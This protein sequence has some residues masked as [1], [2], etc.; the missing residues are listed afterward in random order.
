M[1]LVFFRLFCNEMVITSALFI[2]CV[3]D[4]DARGSY[5]CCA[6]KICSENIVMKV[7]SY[8]T[9]VYDRK[10]LSQ[11]AAGKHDFVFSDKRLTLETAFLA[12]GCEAVT[13]FTSD[14]ASGEVLQSLSAIG[15][16]YVALRSA[17]YDHADLS[18]AG[19]L[20]IRI[21]NVPEYSPYSI[22]E[23]AVAM[24]MAANRKLIESQLLLQLHDFRLDTLVGFDVHGKTVGVVGTGKIGIAFAKIMIGF[25]AVVLATDPVRN[26]DVEKLGIKYVP[27]ENLVETSDIISIHCPLNT[28]TRDLFAAAQ[29]AGMKKGITLINTSRG[30]I[31]S[32][33]DLLEAIEKGII[34]YA[35]LDV[36]DKEKGMFFEDHRDT[37]LTDP[38]FA[39][40]RSYKNVLITGHQSFLTHEALTGIAETTISNIDFWGQGLK[41]PNELH[42]PA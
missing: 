31:V 21:A 6:K 18:I 35:C 3:V 25:G 17:G 10:Y 41:S 9:K 34:G 7:I 29:F 2:L 11:A 12:E 24:L 20:G 30:G 42:A 27:F 32:T 26:P 22:A 1:R 14:I 8:S 39:R 4:L 33:R 13:L 36:Y 40:L 37:V 23:H 19:K 38:E 28:S 15:V 5:T 16:K